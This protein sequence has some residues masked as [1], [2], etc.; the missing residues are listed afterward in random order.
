MS[1]TYRN[2]V[3]NR[4]S[5]IEWSWKSKRT[6]PHTRTCAIDTTREQ[7]THSYC[8]SPDEE[9]CKSVKWKSKCIEWHMRMCGWMNEKEG[10]GNEWGVRLNLNATRNAHSPHL[11][12]LPSSSFNNLTHHHSHSFQH[13]FQSNLH[14]SV[15]ILA[16]WVEAWTPIR[17]VSESNSTTRLDSTRLDSTR[18]HSKHWSF[19][20]FKYM[21]V[22]V[23][24]SHRIHAWLLNISICWDLWAII[25]SNM[26]LW[27]IIHGPNHL[28]ESN[29]LNASRALTSLRFKGC[30][31]SMQTKNSNRR[32]MFAPIMAWL[33]PQKCMIS[34]I[35]YFTVQQQ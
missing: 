32:I 22:C 21:C 28:V 6:C 15:R 12:H 1:C 5:K 3:S 2:K 20:L 19:C 18:L 8:H 13:T 35:R 25:R 10:R 27:S 4:S 33:W 17:Y 14:S 34:S 9:E 26:K 24:N 7:V 29:M 23:L 31:Q 11:H 30:F 16:K